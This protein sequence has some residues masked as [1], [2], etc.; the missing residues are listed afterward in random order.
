MKKKIAD[1]IF[2]IFYIEIRNRIRYQYS[3]FRLAHPASVAPNDI[4]SAAVKP[5]YRRSYRWNLF[6]GLVC[7]QGISASISMR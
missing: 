4:L 2:L 5:R 6:I 1:N 7:L 3:D